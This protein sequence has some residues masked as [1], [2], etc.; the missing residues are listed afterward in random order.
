MQQHIDRASAD[1]DARHQQTQTSIHTIAATA[2]IGGALLV[3]LG[4]AAF[5]GLRRRLSRSTEIS[6]TIRSAHTKLQEQALE[7]DLRLT[8]LYQRQLTT[9]TTIDTVRQ[10]AAQLQKVETD[11]TLVLTIAG[12]LTRIEQN[13]AFMD[14]KVRGVS[15]LR[16]RAAAIRSALAEKGYEIPVLIGTDYHEGDMMEA[17]MEEDESL[18]PGRMIIRRIIRPAVL[19]EGRMIQPAKAVVAYN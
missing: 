11:H 1:S 14:P 9:E 4:I 10:E 5:V 2:A 3:L 17:V 19:Y 13:L 16:S 6:E 15:Q 18:D 12:E 8:E 7:L